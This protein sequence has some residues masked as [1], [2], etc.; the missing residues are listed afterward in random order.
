MGTGWYYAHDGEDRQ[1]PFSGEQLKEFAAQGVISPTATVWKGGVDDGVAAHLVKNL[2]AAPPIPTPAAAAPAEVAVEAAKPPA[3]PEPPKRAPQAEKK[4]SATAVKGCDIVSQDG[5]EARYRMK[6]VECGHK[7]GSSRVVR[8]M[9]KT[10]TSI[11]YCPK[12]KKKRDVVIRC[13]GR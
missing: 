2:F 5:H 3:A 4:G 10:F 1:G 7:D 9:N 11:F 13:Q 6:C 12:C 8:L